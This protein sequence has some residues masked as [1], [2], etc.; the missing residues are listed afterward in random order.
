MSFNIKDKEIGDFDKIHYHYPTQKIYKNQYEKT[1]ENGGYIKIAYSQQ[2]N[3]INIDY[4]ARTSV[5]LNL[6]NVTPLNCP[7]FLISFISWL[8]IK[9]YS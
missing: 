8:F 4:A 7:G 5:F 6:E 2:P 3:V 1:V 9:A